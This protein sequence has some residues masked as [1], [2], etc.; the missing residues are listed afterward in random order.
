MNR[1]QKRAQ[2]KSKV[3]GYH[4]MT[5][6]EKLEKLFQNGITIQDLEKAYEDGKRE[7]LKT[8]S[9]NVLKTC[10][11]AICMAAHDR[12]GF[13][14]KRMIRLLLSVDEHIRDSFTG[15]EAVQKVFDEYGLTIDFKDPQGAVQEE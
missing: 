8:V 6:E 5:H 13:G 2:K 4:R 10:F 7:A 14:K 1:A 11:A 15:A 12:Y 3:P 9:D